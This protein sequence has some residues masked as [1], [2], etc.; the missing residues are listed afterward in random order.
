MIL[1]TSHLG[2]FWHR[3]RRPRP[4]EYHTDAEYHINLK[5]EAERVKA[6]AKKRGG[7]AARQAL[8]QQEQTPAP[9]G[10]DRES[11]PPA[12]VEVWVDVSPRKRSGPP[13][14][15][16]EANELE[17]PLSPA[18]SVTSTGSER[19][20]AQTVP[21]VNGVTHKP[22][23]PLATPNVA[24]VEPPPPPP[25]PESPVPVVKEPTPSPQSTPQPPQ[26]PP[27]ST[28]TANTPTPVPETRTAP[29]VN[30]P[31]AAVGLLSV[32]CQITG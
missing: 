26:A 11:T 16:N 18:S 1:I 19:P 2:K 15:S 3:H 6:T 8:A 9:T 25:R 7:A 20:L 32:P 5:N 10:G 31:P 4:V 22:S 21:K 14:T 28:S 12:K 27:S 29:N 23:T 30:L 17:R 13:P 24:S